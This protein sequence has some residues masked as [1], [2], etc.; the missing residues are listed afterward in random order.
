MFNSRIFMAC[1]VGAAL[2]NPGCSCSSE[3]GAGNGDASADT[4]GTTTGDAHN[5]ITWDS[6][7]SDS[8]VVIPGPDGTTRI[9]YLTPCQGHIYQCGDCVDNDMDGFIDSDDPNCLGPCDNNE[10]GLDLNISGNP[11]APCQEDCYFDQDSGWGND[12]CAWDRR[13]DP[14]EPADHCPHSANPPGAMCPD[15]QMTQCHEFCGPLTP[16]GCDCFGCCH[17]P[18]ADRFIYL[19]SRDSEGNPTCT[20]DTLHD[21]TKCRTCTPVEDCA[22]GCGRCQLCF[23][24]TVDDLPQDCFDDPPDPDERCTQGRQ[25]C[26]F[27]GDDPCPQGHY[28]ITGCCTW[29]G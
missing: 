15:T 5:P 2:F 7:A 13:C 10:A 8:A 25:P 12:K 29:V 6:A 18:G 1:A 3:T 27:P 22:K 21:E 26:G 24:Q 23:G 20:M 17:L 16:N 14:E 11:E 28:C 9:C 4:D 19:G